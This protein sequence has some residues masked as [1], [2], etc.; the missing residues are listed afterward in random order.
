MIDLSSIWPGI[1]V[2]FYLCILHELLTTR[3]A[4]Q[5]IQNNKTANIVRKECPSL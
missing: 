3:S 1:A 5:A 2:G 4:G